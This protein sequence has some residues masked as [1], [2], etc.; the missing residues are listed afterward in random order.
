MAT[1]ADERTHGFG[2]VCP[3]GGC[4]ADG[5]F[6]GVAGAHGERV[7]LGKGWLVS[8][9]LNTRGSFLSDAAEQSDVRAVVLCGV[10]ACSES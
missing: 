4:L 3:S 7:G 2:I 10:W 6:G 9:K 5:R 8:P 1:M